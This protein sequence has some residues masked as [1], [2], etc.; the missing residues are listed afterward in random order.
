MTNT[1][2][3]NPILTDLQNGNYGEASQQVLKAELEGDY[4][5]KD[6]V[7]LY[8]DKGMIYHYQGEYSKSNEQFDKAEWAIEELYT[9]SIS[10]GASSMLLNDNALD[11]SGEVYENLYINIFKALNYIHLDDF[12]GAYVEVKKVNDKLNLLDTKYEEYAASINNSDE[13]APEIKAEELDYYNNVFANY[14]SSVVFK[15]E[16]EYDNSRISREKMFEAWNT[17]TDVYDYSKPGFLFDSTITASNYILNIIAL[18]GKAPYKQSVGARITT[19]DDFVT[20]SDP[21]NFWVD[22][23]PFPGIEYGWNF[24]F[25][26]PELVEDGTEVYDI[27]I[28]I[29]STHYGNLELLE[30]MANVARKTFETNKGII[31]FKTIIRAVLKGVGAGSLGKN[32]K[33]NNDDLLGDILVALTNAAVDATEHADL[34]CWRTMPSYCFTTQIPLAKGTYNIELRYIGEDGSVIKSELF[35]DFTIGDDVNLIESFYL[36]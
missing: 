21:T 4:A 34:R 31:F 11:Y 15:A 17:Y 14:L 3:Y 13:S 32:I 19:F 16:G 23:I 30:N 7:L 24:K 6:R 20:V 8:L 1:E 12:D 33:K 9:K 26:F 28:Y 2:F 5:D 29:D 27:E 35:N 22:A 18:A 25:A 10:K 36:N